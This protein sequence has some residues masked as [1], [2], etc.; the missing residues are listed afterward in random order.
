MKFFS[1]ADQ[2]VKDCI[3]KEENTFFQQKRIFI[4]L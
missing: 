4:Y 1:R 2:D 3:K